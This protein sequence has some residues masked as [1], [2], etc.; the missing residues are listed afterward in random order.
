MKITDTDV[1]VTCPGRNYVL[2]KIETDNG[3]IG[4][5]DATLNGREKAV[6]SALKFHILPEL[7][8][9]DARRIEDIWQMF[10][11]NTYWRGGPVL[12]SAL[13]GVDI[14]LWDLKGKQANLPVYELLGG[15]TR[16]HAKF[17]R[18]CGAETVAKIVENCKEA[19]NEGVEYLRVNLRSDPIQYIDLDNIAEGVKSTREKIGPE[20]NLLVDFHGRADPVEAAKLAKQLEPAELYFLEDPVRPE[21]PDVFE[22]IRTHSTTPLAMGELFTNPWEMLPLLERN[23]VDFIRTDLSH[24]GGIT[25]A[26]KLA[27][28]G[29]HHYV[30]TAFHGPP[31]LSPVGFAATVHLDI[32]IPNFGVQEHPEYFSEPEDSTFKSMFQLPSPSKI[33][34]VFSGGAFISDVEG[35]VNVS[36]RP[37]L[38]IEVN[39]STARQYDFKRSHLPKPRNPDGSVQDW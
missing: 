38:G 32:S 14:A 20:P 29:D 17:Y 10:F 9:K 16:D 24:I 26:D 5:G 25:A 2:V 15:R 35:A 12:N 8:G 37:G 3:L 30:K 7:E 31:D 1:I 23:L 6:E 4:W 18:H 19:I 33:D 28:I 21:N 36:D 39:E 27:A 11:R 13:A 34:E 22:L